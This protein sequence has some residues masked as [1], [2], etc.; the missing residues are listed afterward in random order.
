MSETVMADAAARFL[1]THKEHVEQMFAAWIKWTGNADPREV[2]LVQ[3]WR[4]NSLVVYIATRAELG[5]APA[6]L[7]AP[8]PPPAEEKPHLFA[9]GRRCQ[10]LDRMH[11]D[12]NF[13][14]CR[15][16]GK[17]AYAHPKTLAP[18]AAGACE[19]HEFECDCR[20][21]D[22]PRCGCIPC[23]CACHYDDPEALRT[24]PGCG[25]RRDAH[26]GGGR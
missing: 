16:C 10:L 1:E 6:F 9:C 13:H 23:L 18:P 7:S 5:I 24:Y 14:A 26:T 4:G 8:D 3:E 19:G 17:P 20:G 22:H 11:G 2:A 15:D 12:G 21:A 25:K